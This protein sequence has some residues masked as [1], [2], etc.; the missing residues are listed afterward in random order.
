MPLLGMERPSSQDIEWMCTICGFDNKSRSKFCHLCG[1]SHEFTTDYAN[2][3]QKQKVIKGKKK[4]KEIIIPRDAQLLETTRFSFTSQTGAVSSSGA[5]SMKSPGLTENERREALNYRR[6]NQLT[7]RQKG[8]RRRKMWQRVVDEETGELVWV[9]V[10]FKEAMKQTKG[11]AVGPPLSP[12]PRTHSSSDHNHSIFRLFGS[13]HAAASASSPPLR[14]TSMQSASTTGRLDSFDAV[15]N[16]HSPGYASYLDPSGQI[17]WEKLE[18]G[19]MNV[20]PSLSYHAYGGGGGGGGGRPLPQPSPSLHG[21]HAAYEHLLPDLIPHDKQTILALSF[22]EKL[23]WFYDTLTVLQ[24]PWTDGFIR[25][26]I[27][28]QTL[29]EDSFQQVMAMSLQD[30]GLHRWMRIQFLHE[31]GIDAGGIEREWFLLLTQ[32]IFEHQLGLFTHSGGSS[33]HINP[34]SHLIYPERCTDYFHFVG[35]V[36]AKAIMEQQQVPALLSIPLRKHLLGM[37]IT[38]SDL[39]FVDLELYRNLCWLRDYEEEEEEPDGGVK[40]Q[41]EGG[42]GKG[43]PPAM[44][45]I[46]C[47]GLVFSVDY[48]FGEKDEKEGDKVMSSGGGGGGGG[49]ETE[50]KD[51][52]PSAS[53]RVSSAMGIER[54]RVYQESYELIP[55]GADIL[56]TSATKDEYLELRLRHRMLDSMKGQLEAFLKGF[57]EVLPAEVVSVFDYQ[58]LELLM[59][60]L[61]TIDLDDWKRHTEYLGEYYRLGPRH[62]I[63][64]WFWEVVTAYSDEERIRLLQFTTGCSRLPAKGFRAL[65]SNDGNVRRFNIQSIRKIVSSS[66]PP[67]LR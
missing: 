24:R 37:P 18:S 15:L 42:E 22:Q 67:S 43:P 23:T 59:C 51:G 62:K 4:K 57:Y 2:E 65:Q 38:F 66:R 16:S 56:V 19:S 7:L 53:S 28:R 45:G 47:L 60:G 44:D 50:T 39:E 9:R 20:N 31:P 55:N 21:I 12:A 6:L 36:L 27:N 33:Y 48:F 25:L 63:I 26:E 11:G 35:R 52:R 46:E 5:G 61:P 1:T 41:S 49:G 17:Q 64:R 29:F 54:G 10:N 30:G 8:A 40:Q 32:R 34:L 14:T 13:H 3:K 58:E